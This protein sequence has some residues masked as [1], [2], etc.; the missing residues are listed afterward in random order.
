MS[1][2]RAVGLGS[3]QRSIGGVCG[4]VLAVLAG[5]LAGGAAIASPADLERVE[6][7]GSRPGEVVRKD[8]KRACP[9]VEA[10]LVSS[11]SRVH[12]HAQYSGVTTVSFRLQNGVVQEIHQRGEPYAYREDVQR[13]VR[14]LQ[15]R[16][17]VGAA[18]GVAGDGMYVMQVV[19]QDEVQGG[20]EGRRVAL[21]D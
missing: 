1:V 21:L 2:L 19:F 8:V 14:R 12:Y 13:A 6:V 17:D 10:A 20:D 11:L 5:G 18:A 15:C 3:S 16:G 4:A 7:T 9:G